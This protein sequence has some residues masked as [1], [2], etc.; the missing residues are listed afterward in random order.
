VSVISNI[1]PNLCAE[2]HNAWEAGDLT[3]FA[4]I[5]D[6][7]A[8]LAVGVFCEPSPAPVKYAASQLGLCE[9]EVRLPMVPASD[10]AMAIV[11]DA[12]EKAGLL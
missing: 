9:N 3:T 2:R 11:D 8:P 10:N 7:L 1:A 5:R 6:Q 4:K 12:L